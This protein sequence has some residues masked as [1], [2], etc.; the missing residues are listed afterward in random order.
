MTAPTAARLTT[1]DA[2]DRAHSLAAR[3]ALTAAEVDRTAAFPFANFEALRDAGML[4]LTVPREFGGEGM[5]LAP[6]CRVIETIAGGEPSTALVLAMHYIYHAVPAL[7]GRW[8]P[9]MHEQLCR[10][11]L[12]GI[13][14]IN[15]IRVEPEL[16]TPTRGGLPAATA[17]RTADGWSLSGRKMYATGS[18]LLEH[19]LV[20][21]RTEGDDPQVGYF[22]VRPGLPGVRIEETWDHLGM[23]ATGSHDLVLDAVP[24]PTE[25]ALDVRPVKGWSPPDVWQGAWNN[26][27]LAALYHGIAKAARTWLT[28]YLNERKPANLGASLATLPR[29]QSAVGEMDA[30]LWASDRLIYTLAEATDRDGYTGRTAFD[31]SMAKYI[32]TNNA[33]KAV[34]I[35]LSLIGNPGLSRTNPLERHHR[36]VLCSRIHMPQDDMVTL[37][38]GKAALGVT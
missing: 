22:L 8:A 9:A 25:Y 19:F 26:L 28:G 6:V 33:V 35:A 36:D 4:N 27:V 15:V 30:L 16:G 18:P 38:A 12:D 5:G 3:F 10:E 20:W 32:A 29:F 13:A 17:T 11:S 7:S 14:L 2:I 21:A 1:E 37:M 31:S 24:L 34:D 23:R